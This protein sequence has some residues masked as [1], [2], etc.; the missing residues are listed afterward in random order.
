M[1]GRLFFASDTSRLLAYES[2]ATYMVGSANFVEMGTD[3]GAG[4]WYSYSSFSNLGSISSSLVT[5]VFPTAYGAAPQIFL[6]P[7]NNPHFCSVRVSTTT[8]F[9][10]FVSIVGAASF[11]T[12]YWRSMGTI[13]GW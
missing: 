5:F 1:T 11:I 13:S 12:L 9:S 4:A 3:G 10:S 8:N 6:Q 7:Q 2:S